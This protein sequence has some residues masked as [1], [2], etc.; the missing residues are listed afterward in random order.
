M[1]VC[2]K[3]RT[4]DI[5][6]FNYF[7]LKNKNKIHSTITD[8]CIGIATQNPNQNLILHIYLILNSII[9]N[10]FFYK[11]NDSFFIVIIII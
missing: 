3:K 7:V 1:C 8:L 10:V 5:K 11:F 4:I 9:I 6:N 2:I